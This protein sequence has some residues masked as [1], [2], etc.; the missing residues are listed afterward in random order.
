M[1]STTLVFIA[2]L[3]LL[4]IPMTI[5]VG[6]KRLRTDIHFMDGGNEDLMWRMRAHGNFTETVPIALLAMAGA[7][8]SGT[9]T[10]LIWALGAL[11][12]CGRLLHYG[13]VR[14]YGWANGRAGGMAMTF[15]AMGGA[16]L[17]ILIGTLGFFP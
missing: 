11:L 15:L 14:R 13:T 1:I 12:V 2:I 6:L 8:I 17:C 4:Q 10:T 9:P 7:E 16:A 5:A 3:A